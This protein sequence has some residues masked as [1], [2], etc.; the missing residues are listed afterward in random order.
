MHRTGDPCATHSHEAM[1]QTGPTLSLVIV[2][3]S[4]LDVLVKQALQVLCYPSFPSRTKP[5]EHGKTR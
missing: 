1:G 4:G 2:G 3:G 5:G